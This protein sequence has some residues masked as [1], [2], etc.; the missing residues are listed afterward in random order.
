MYWPK[1]HHSTT[2]GCTIAN[3]VRR[4]TLHFIQT[5]AG[6]ISIGLEPVTA[7]QIRNA[8]EAACFFPR[9][10]FPQKGVIAKFGSLAVLAT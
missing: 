7:S 3:A 1:G 9:P 5:S 10:N 8:C 4:G 2:S 6:R